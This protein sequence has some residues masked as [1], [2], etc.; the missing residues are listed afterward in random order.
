LSEQ[1]RL[2]KVLLEINHV[3]RNSMLEVALCARMLRKGACCSSVADKLD[4]AVKRVF[5]ILDR[6]RSGREQ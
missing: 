5:A 1:E 3:V 4:G 6:Y 2:Q